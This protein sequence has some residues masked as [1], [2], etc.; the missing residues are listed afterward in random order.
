LAAVFPDRSR[1]ALLDEWEAAEADKLALSHLVVVARKEP[2]AV[3]Y[4]GALRL[5]PWNKD[6]LLEYLLNAHKDRCAAVMGRLRTEDHGWLLGRPELWRIVLDR[7]ADDLQLG[8]AQAAL[9]RHLHRM[10]PEKQKRTR[11]GQACLVAISSP[12]E[13]PTT[14][15]LPPSELSAETLRLLRH[16]PVQTLLAAEAIA[17]DLRR[18]NAGEWRGARLPRSLI[19]ATIPLLTGQGKAKEYLE[20]LLAKGHGLAG[21]FLYALDAEWAPKAGTPN[22]AGAFLENAR[23][24]GIDL[25]GTCLDGADL[26]GA[27][28]LGANL[29][30]AKAGATNFEGARLRGAR[31]Q[32][33]RAA[34]A[35][36]SAA[37]LTSVRGHDAFFDHA[38]LEDANLEDAMLRDSVFARA[39]LQGAIFRGAELNAS[40]FIGATLAE[41]DFTGAILR[42]ANLSGL[43]LHDAEFRGADFTEANLAGADLEYMDLP[44]AVFDDAKLDS[45]YLTGTTMPQARFV[46][47]DLRN[48]G[49]ADIDWERANLSGADLRGASFHLGS[50]RSGLVGSPIACEGSR[51]GFYTDDF[52][53]Q[54]YKAP[55]DIRK[56]NLRGA[57]LR[58]ANLEGVDFYLVDLRDALF[59]PAYEAH[60]RR[61]GAILE[62]KA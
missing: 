48:S 10:W 46:N 7:L 23:W 17:D 4:L 11:A 31:L 34:A 8:D 40:S 61:C 56:A 28:L 9:Q 33:F 21:S 32:T 55:E 6:D 36:F 16:Q 13:Q 2:S 5:C 30:G 53:E 60:L 37:D 3:F 45:A 44:G 47:A 62:T 38:N 20:R 27:D 57:D 26:S 52:E 42:K 15:T 1:L 54:H 50:T 39:N 24:P 19:R 49:L 58:G 18:E 51:T 35:N 25:S 41:A 22:L 29:S 14:V 43:K 59:D 12:P